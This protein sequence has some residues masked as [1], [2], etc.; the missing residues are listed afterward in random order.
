MTNLLLNAGYPRACR[1]EWTKKSSLRGSKSDA[2]VGRVEA[3]PDP[4][5]TAGYACGDPA[6]HRTV[7]L[8]LVARIHGNRSNAAAHEDVDR[9]NA[10][11]DDGR[12]VAE[13]RGH[14]VRAGRRPGSVE[15]RRGTVLPRHPRAR[16][17]ER[18]GGPSLRGGNASEAIQWRSSGSPRRCAARDDEIVLLAGQ[19]DDNT[20]LNASDARARREDP[21]K[22]REDARSRRRGSP[23]RVRR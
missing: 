22:P 7:I 16:R 12:W 11:G 3:K 8:A 4:P 2:A 14:R 19:P 18:T 1:E 20:A 5:R 9:R 17:E 15:A 13:A 21:R 23:H 10:C 6:L